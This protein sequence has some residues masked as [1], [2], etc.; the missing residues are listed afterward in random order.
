MSNI[1]DISKG[2]TQILFRGGTAGDVF[3]KT[4]QSKVFQR[5]SLTLENQARLL[6][7]LGELEKQMNDDVNKRYNILQ[8]NALKDGRR[9]YH[10]IGIEVGNKFIKII[11]NNGTQTSVKYFIEVGTGYIYGAKGYKAYNPNRR[12]GTLKTIDDWNWSGYEGESKKGES[13]LVPKAE[14]R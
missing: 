9:G 14:R 4:G 2:R 12:F 8:V 11:E 3:V 1:S 5:S 7:F 6:M 13:T 10:E